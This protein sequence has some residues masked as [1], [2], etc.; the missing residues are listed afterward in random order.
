MSSQFWSCT[1]FKHLLSA[2][3]TNLDCSIL[4]PVY[5]VLFLA[6]PLSMSA[7]DLPLPGVEGDLTI[8]AGTTTTI[9]AT[10]SDSTATFRWYDALVGGNLLTSQAAFSTPL[11]SASASYFVEQNAS[12]QTSARRRV[13]V[14][15][16]SLPQNTIPQ[17]VV[18][19]PTWICQDS[20]S[21]LFAE[22]DE[23]AGQWIYWYD[24][25]VDGNLLS[26]NRS[27]TP[28]EVAPQQTTTYY[29]QSVTKVD[30]A[31]FTFTGAPQMWIVPDGVTEVEVDAYGARGGHSHCCSVPSAIIDAGK[32]GRVEGILQVN[33]GDT[34]WMYVGGAGTNSPNNFTKDP[35]YAGGWNGGGNGGIVVP[36]VVELPTSAWEGRVWKT[37]SWSPVAAAALLR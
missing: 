1:S 6:M 3:M 27:E 16:T 22:V 20:S 23:A 36:A 29:A 10:S 30:T 9:T 2:L 7:Q 15:V 19:S 26:Q 8:C 4:Y 24:A 5:C 28:F 11:L 21:R 34:L 17:N 12:G 14:L 13:E 18:A 31:T 32:G 25:P 33:P 35:L 37:G